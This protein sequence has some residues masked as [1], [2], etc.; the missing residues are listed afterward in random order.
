MMIIDFYDYMY[1]FFT[2]KKSSFYYLEESRKATRPPNPY[3]TFF[4]AN[5]F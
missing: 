3:Y 2:L 5:C 1:I 4:Q